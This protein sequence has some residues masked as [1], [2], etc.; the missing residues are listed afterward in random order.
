MHLPDHEGDVAQHLLYI[1]VVFMKM[2]FHPVSRILRIAQRLAF[3][4]FAWMSG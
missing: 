1:C 3:A 4:P 2:P